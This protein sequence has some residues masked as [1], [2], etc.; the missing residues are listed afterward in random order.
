VRAL[1]EYDGA[2]A[3]RGDESG[4]PQNFAPVDETTRVVP[5]TWPVGRPIIWGMAVRL[6][7]GLALLVPVTA[8]LAMCA[9]GAAASAPA[10]QETQRLQA[11]MDVLVDLPN[12]PPGAIA[13][14]H[15]GSERRV[16]RAG[17]ANVAT[18]AVPRAD[19]H[20]RV[21]STAKAYSGA[22]VLALVEDDVMSLRDTVGEW[23]PWVPAE[24]TPITLRQ[25]LHHTSGLPDFSA[26]PQFLRHLVANLDQPL[27][28]RRLLR[29]VAGDP[30]EFPPG[31]RY[32]YSN[33]D[34]VVAALMA[35]EAA[36]TR[37]EKLL[38]R[39]VVGPL[40]LAGTSLPRGVRMPA[41]AMRGY[42][43]EADGTTEDVTELVA[44]GY[45]W[46]SGGVVSTPA[47]QDRFIRGYIGRDL[48]GRQRQRAQFDWLVES[49]SEPPGPGA[50]AAGLAVFRYRTGCGTVYGHT[51]NTLGYTQ[52]FAASQDGRR[53]VVVAVNRQTTPEAAPAVFRRLRSV[54][55]LAVCAVNAD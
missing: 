11:A 9:T 10:T 2:T 15:S 4:R 29:F 55:A 46:A 30:L 27:A 39:L 13:V 32:A 31:S 14:V 3:H 26:D 52:F 16:L 33:S 22:V 23:L 45:A 8:V 28:P 47:D 54:F 43:R 36:G 1:R 12:G 6:R 44:A 25:V 20:M 40:G 37:Y 5:F 38:A 17:V 24:W 42:D 19:M 51:G 7:G 41:P 21:A 34:N 35:A 18:G 48:F 49:R 50:N 53:S